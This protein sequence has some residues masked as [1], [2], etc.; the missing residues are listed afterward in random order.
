MNNELFDLSG[1]VALVTGASKGLGKAFAVALASAGADIALHARNIDDLKAVKSLIETRGRR[2]EIFYTDVL[3]KA[4][5]DDSV[6][7][8]LETF[9]QIDILVNNAGVNVRKPVLEL[10]AD[11]WDMVLNTNLRGYFLMARAVVPAMLSRGSGKVIN[12]ASIFG[13]VALPTQLAYASSKGGVMQMTKVMALEWA[14]QGVQVNAIGP[15]YFE[16]PLVAQL[17]NDP[18]RYQF[19]VDRTPAGRW[20]QPEELAGLIIFLAS[21]GSDFIT[22]Q[23]IFIDGG[24]TIW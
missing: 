19:I 3:D 20:G 14:K 15:T 16:T 11:E 7:S 2:A 24:W 18:E 5:I 6:A 17:R 22:G 4:C 8:T 12:V 21:R 10:S 9:G 23:T 13:A 1:R